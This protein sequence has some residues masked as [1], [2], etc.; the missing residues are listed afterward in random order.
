MNYAEFIEQKAL[1]DWL[2]EK[3]IKYFAIPNGGAR[4]AKTGKMLKDM[5][6]KAGVPDLFICEPRGCYSGCFVELKRAHGGQ[7]SKAQREW[8]TTLRGSGYQAVVCAGWLTAAR[9]IE[10][11]L[12][13]GR[14]YEMEDDEL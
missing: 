3:G 5:G 11:Y 6:V 9:E 12:E 2:D 4:S 8:L 14:G 13:T 1:C 10:R 7:T